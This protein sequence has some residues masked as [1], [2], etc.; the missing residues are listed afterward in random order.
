[1]AKRIASCLT[2][3]L[4]AALAAWGPG[5]AQAAE[6]D[7]VTLRI[8]SYGGPFDQVLKDMVAT[9]L[10]QKFGASVVYEPG[11]SAEAL[12]KLIAAKD[13][14]HLDILMIDS[15]NMPLAI[16]NGVIEELS[17]QDL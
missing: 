2:V 3:A 1:M 15:A 10:K 12:S 5:V 6:F 17:E 8:N 4:V 11:T 16:Q 9:P 13:N 7:G 14:P